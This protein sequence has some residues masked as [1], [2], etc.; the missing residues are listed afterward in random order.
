MVRYSKEQKTET[1]SKYCGGAFSTEISKE[2]GI[3][4]DTVLVLKK[5]LL[6][7]KNTTVMKPQ[8]NVEA[9][10]PKKH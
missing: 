10:F 6:G 7:S 5:S 9:I 2:Y 3:V 1:V 8:K 4:L